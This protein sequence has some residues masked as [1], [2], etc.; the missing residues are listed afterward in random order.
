MRKTSKELSFE[1][2]SRFQQWLWAWRLRRCWKWAE[3]D[4]GQFYGNVGYYRARGKLPHDILKVLKD[5]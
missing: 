5:A 2:G 3:K 4:L 1:K